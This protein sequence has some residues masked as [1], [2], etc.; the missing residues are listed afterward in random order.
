MSLQTGSE[1]TSAPRIPDSSLPGPFPVGRYAARLREQ[2]RSFRRVQ[3]LGELV[4]LRTART[5]VYFELRDGSGAIPCA[6]WLSDWET[7]LSSSG[8]APAEGMQVVVAGG[9]DY[10][11]GS[12]ASSPAFSFNVTDLRIAGEGDLLAQIDRLRKQ[13]DAEGLL[14]RQRR[15]ALP[16]LPATIGVVTGESGKARDD[17][18]AALRRRGWA[19]RLVWAFAPVQDRHAAPAITRALGDL[20][21]LEEVE[22]VIVARGG[23][24]LADLLCFCDETLC[25][26]VALLAVPVIASVGH[27]TDRTLL[28]D[29]AAV[30]CSTPTHAAEAAVAIDCVAARRRQLE[31]AARLR[32]HGGRVLHER[33][34]RAHAAARLRD[35]GR[36]A[37]LERARR[38]ALLSRAPGVHVDRQREQLR[39]KLREIRAGSRRRLRDE[40]ERTG[41]RALVISRKS[42][43]TLADCGGRRARE[44]ERLALALA[45]H[46]PQRTLERGYALAQAPDG[47]PVSSASEARERRTLTLRFADGSVGAEVSER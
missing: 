19:G 32:E 7:M 41:K 16:A 44:L 4:N 46:D 26:T 3:L 12:A 29:V 8:Q 17:L 34:R 28:D 40:L 35:H 14:E 31:L 42:S 39:Q 47:S 1:G 5:R 37:V 13:L 21:A 2:L 20:A 10:Y 6:A 30:S 15:L 43:S 11:P 33:E 36:R 38:L 24:S 9:C 23:G 45:G 18:L 22:V 27:H 25:R